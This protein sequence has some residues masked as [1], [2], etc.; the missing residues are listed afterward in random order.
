LTLLG[1][2][3]TI[4]SLLWFIVWSMHTIQNLLW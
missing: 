2:K 1:V 3:P 4:K